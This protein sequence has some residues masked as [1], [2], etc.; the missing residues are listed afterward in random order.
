MLELNPDNANIVYFI[1]MTFQKEGKM[2]KAEY[3]FEKAIK[4]KPELERLKVSQFN[5]DGRKL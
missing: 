3:Y 5:W 4:M 1:G 2:N